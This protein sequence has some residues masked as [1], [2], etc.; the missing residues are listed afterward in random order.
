M[1]LH[2]IIAA[3]SP[4]LTTRSGATLK[5]DNGGL[6]SCEFPLVVTTDSSNELY[7][8]NGTRVF[9][10]TS[11]PADDQ[12]STWFNV[13]DLNYCLTN[14]FGVMRTQ[15]NGTFGDD[16]QQ[17]QFL[18]DDST[19]LQAHCKKGS[20]GY[21]RTTVDL[22][23]IFTLENGVLSCFDIP[24]CAIDHPNIAPTADCDY[25]EVYN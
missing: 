9:L 15:A 10:N 11:C 7:I 1:F 13:I 21:V 4:F 2:L 5:K 23:P 8:Y 18:H 16:C 25:Y 3:L 17:F 24:A 20:G 6:K 22:A 19:V 14:D 12:R